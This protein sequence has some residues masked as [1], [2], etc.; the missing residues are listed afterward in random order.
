MNSSLLELDTER[1]KQA[2]SNAC[3]SP[4]DGN[5]PAWTFP[6]W[7][8]SPSDV[9][10]P[11]LL[12]H[13]H[14]H[15][16][17]IQPG[18]MDPVA[19]RFHCPCQLTYSEF[20]PEPQPSQHH[21]ITGP[22][23]GPLKG[24]QHRS[25]SAPWS[26][27]GRIL[28]SMKS[29]DFHDPLAGVSVPELADCQQFQE[30]MTEFTSR[31]TQP[32]FCGPAEDGEVEPVQPVFHTLTP[33]QQKDMRVLGIPSQYQQRRCPL[34]ESRDEPPQA[35]PARSADTLC[36]MKSRKPC[37]CT[38]SQCLKLYCEC[39]SNG[40]MCINC[41][42]SNC[43]NDAEHEAKRL[44]AIMSCLGRNPDAFRSKMT[45]G[46]K[47]GDKGCSCKRSGCLKNYCECYEANIM[48]TSSC[49]CLGC[50]NYDEVSDVAPQEKSADVF[51]KSPDSVITV[52]VVEAVCGCLLAKAEEAESEAPGDGGVQAELR[53]LEEFGYCLAQIAKAV[54]KKD[55]K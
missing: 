39:F 13:P 32:G 45:G 51:S 44:Q 40:V 12:S 47:G 55:T 26:T 38:R 9:S 46:M 24:G 10:R 31:F 7:A 14:L 11:G 23:P 16:E 5:V 4:D 2:S 54:S 8:G 42:C 6:V 53:V 43:H 50:R 21:L 20:L 18:I 33:S 52:A 48:C 22:V 34:Y 1:N 35:P 17:A 41:D 28:C 15:Q 29:G 19:L 30:G 49:K 36:E 27:N 3:S 37:H 25:V